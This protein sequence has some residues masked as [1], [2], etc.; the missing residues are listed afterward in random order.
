MRSL[1]HIKILGISV[2]LFLTISACG[3]DTP[4]EEFV[5]DFGTFEALTY[6]VAGLPQGISDSN[7]EEFIPLISP[8]L[9]FYDLVLVQEDFVYHR[10]LKRDASHP[11]QSTPKD[12]DTRLIADG[13]NRFSQFTF[14]TLKREQWVACYGELD[15]GAI[16]GAADCLAEKGFSMARTTFASGIIVDIYNH[17]AEAG[18]AVSDAEARAAGYAQFSQFIQTHSAGNAIIIAGDTNLHRADPVDGPLLE[19]FEVA[20]GLTDACHFLDCGTESIDR[21]LFRNSDTVEITPLT[22]R[23]ADEFVTETGDPLSDHQAVHVGF[24]WDRLEP[25]VE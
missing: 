17:H 5:E 19:G 20:N 13:L 18:G 1:S 8:L 10:D 7:P 22:W 6:N 12:P 3:T 25:N 14:D 21:F 4:E 24:R 2:A 16:T 15:G 23:Y 11:F 9:N